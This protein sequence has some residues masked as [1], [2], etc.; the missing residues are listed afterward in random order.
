MGE[1]DTPIRVDW[2]GGHPVLIALNF[3]S[4][5]LGQDL[6]PR[7]SLWV[8]HLESK[9]VSGGLSPGQFRQP[10]ASVFVCF[11]IKVIMLIIIW[12]L[13]KSQSRDNLPAFLPSKVNCF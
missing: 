7:V 9:Q 8:H 4:R 2:K 11:A 6:E 5:H 10:W 13:P 1:R 3:E 12:Q